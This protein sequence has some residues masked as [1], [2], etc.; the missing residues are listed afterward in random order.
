MVNYELL[1][2]KYI[3]HVGECEGTDFVGY[4]GVYMSEVEFTPEE[5]QKMEEISNEVWK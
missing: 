1:L 5:K 4:I 2:K 3:R